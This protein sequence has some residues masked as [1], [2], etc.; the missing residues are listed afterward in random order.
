ML[1]K[2]Y[3]TNQPVILVLLPIIA[4]LI[5]GP[6]FGNTNTIEIVNTTPV[7]RFFVSK[8]HLLN[9]LIALALIITTA[10]VLN[11]TINQNEF[12]QQNIYLPSLLSIILLSILPASNTI[13][14][15]LFSNLFLALSFRRLINIHS[16]V[17]CKSEIFDVSLLLLTGSLFYPP[18]LLFTPIIWITLMIF[19]PFQ[20][21]EWVSP[22]IALAIFIVYFATSFL[23]TDKT[24]YYEFS[25]ILESS[26]YK[27]NNYSLIFYI[28]AFLSFL[29]VLLGMIQIHLKRKSSSIRYK[30]MTSMI[31]AFFIIGLINF[32]IS[33]LY[34]FAIETVYVTLIPFTIAISYFLVYFKK[35]IIV[36]F[37]LFIL[38][39]LVILNNWI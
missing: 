23:F 2:I 34:T 27:N 6:S 9:Q 20:W 17:S 32:G 12:F 13:H 30:K 39:L 7:Y 15:I 31:L 4:L 35:N 5:W 21:K 3:K 25:N 16:Q 1:L 8:T 14:P 24:S 28:F 33:Y 10:L 37:G 22:F 11:T 18:T 38:L 26:I 36:E 19:R 29:F